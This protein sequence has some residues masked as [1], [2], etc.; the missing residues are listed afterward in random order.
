MDP[1]HVRVVDATA[2]STGFLAFFKAIPWPEIAA[3][4]SAM[5]LIGR[6]LRW[7]WKLWRQR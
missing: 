3:F 2:V 7:L 6:F 4:C 1:Q 5:Y